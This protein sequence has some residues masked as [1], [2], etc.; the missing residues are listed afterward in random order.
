[1][2]LAI[3]AASSYAENRSVAELSHV[4][5]EVDWLCQRLMEADA[6]FTVHFLT[7]ERGLAE[8]LEQVLA[9]AAEPVQELLFFFSGYA[10]VLRC[11]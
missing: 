6:G 5:P 11:Y 9:S 8:R 3:V 10:V 2:R 1:M 7:A 4:G